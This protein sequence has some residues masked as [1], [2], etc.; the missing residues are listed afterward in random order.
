MPHTIYLCRH[1]DTAWSPIRRLAGRTDLELS[2]AGEAT[3]RQVGVRLAGVTFD[4]IWVS[5]LTRAR[6]TAE[7]AGLAGVFDP[8]LVEMNFGRY[9][10]RTVQEIRVERPGFTCLGDGCPDGETA[11]DLARRIDPVLAE[12]RALDG[13]T[14]IVA[15]SVILRVLT[16]RY[17]GL[18]PNHGRN[19][20]MAPGGISI[21]DYDPID[22]A[23]AILAWNL[24]H[25][26][27]A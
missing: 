17:L 6:R 11:A 26:V 4:R 1:G 22:D 9:E 20:M 13:T 18:S 5:P 8:R 12:L 3:A 19:F 16:A 24:R 15:H 21:L 25:Q 7:L 27:S 10:G 14:L 2:P 23:P